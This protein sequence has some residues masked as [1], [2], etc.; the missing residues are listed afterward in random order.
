MNAKPAEH[1][2]ES[3]GK[4]RRVDDF[5]VLVFG[6]GMA[7]PIGK[8]GYPLTSE[9][10]PDLDVPWEEF[11]EIDEAL[12][13]DQA[14]K[15]DEAQDVPHAVLKGVYSTIATGATAIVQTTLNSMT[16]LRFATAFLAGAV[17]YSRHWLSEEW[18]DDTSEAHI[19]LE[20]VEDYQS[21]TSKP[22]RDESSGVLTYMHSRPF[23]VSADSGTLHSSWLAVPRDRDRF[24]TWHRKFSVVERPLFSPPP[25]DGRPT[26]LCN[27]VRNYTER[28]CFTDELWQK[29]HVDSAFAPADNFQVLATL[30][31]NKPVCFAQRLG[32]GTII[33]LPHTLLD[34][35]LSIVRDALSSSEAAMDCPPASWTCL[36]QKT[37][38]SSREPAPR[39]PDQTFA[40]GQTQEELPEYEVEEI[41]IAVTGKT[42][43]T[44]RLQK[45][46]E[47]FK[48]DLGPF[49]ED[50]RCK[51]ERRLRDAAVALIKASFATGDDPKRNRWIP[52]DL[53][54]KKAKS[55]SNRC[56]DLKDRFRK[57][58]QEKHRLDLVFT[59]S[60][61]IIEFGAP[62]SL[63]VD[64]KHYRAN[65]RKLREH[66][67]ETFAEF[68]E[69]R[70]RYLL[71]G[72][73]KMQVE[74]DGQIKIRSKE[75]SKKRQGRTR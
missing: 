37:N 48:V 73:K 35:V 72:D 22:F 34:P 42:E 54:A 30:G 39:P 24:V 9:M 10:G 41:A 19:Q 14:N 47:E 11:F 31:P 69:E 13:Y 53:T 58:F 33:V 5:D 43:I 71:A 38:L 50:Q 46:G 4:L 32:K 68:E 45:K 21:E 36:M 61:S 6:A 26:F 1:R 16:G 56:Y 8:E 67:F 66:A 15:G 49:G 60:S 59:D 55:L 25:D 74:L 7:V 40:A 27:P 63:K 44:V 23:P 20:A 17:E 52:L 29:K 75:L 65:F 12:N 62:K 2:V 28:V 64:A 18:P 51:N 3:F 57:Y 70:K